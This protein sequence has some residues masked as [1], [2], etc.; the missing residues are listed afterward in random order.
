MSTTSESE[1][2]DWSQ[3]ERGERGAWPEK[4]SD[5]KIDALWD[6]ITEVLDKHFDRDSD[7]DYPVNIHL[8]DRTEYGPLHYQPVPYDHKDTPIEQCL[9]LALLNL[10][11]AMEEFNRLTRVK[12]LR[13]KRGGLCKRCGLPTNDGYDHDS[14]KYCL[15]ALQSVKD[16]VSAA[17]Q[18]LTKAK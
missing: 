7:G 2:V 14:K 11:I 9:E 16:Q 6:D 15:K 3:L 18:K 5:G 1:Y 10:H 17:E 13:D 4:I 12:A 8:V